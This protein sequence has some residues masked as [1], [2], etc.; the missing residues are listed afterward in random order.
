MDTNMEDIMKHFNLCII[1]SVDKYSIDNLKDM[2][3]SFMQT[4]KTTEEYGGMNIRLEKKH[5][6]KLYKCNQCEF[7]ANG[8]KHIYEHKKEHIVITGWCVINVDIQQR[9]ILVL[10]VML[11][12]NTLNICSNMY[13]YVKCIENK[14]L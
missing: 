13:L 14:H 12:V 11:D 3:A 1:T 2:E 9:L 10:I 8:T 5:E 6:Q 7:R 4:L